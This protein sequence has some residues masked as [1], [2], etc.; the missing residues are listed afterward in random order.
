MS[1]ITVIGA[2]IT[3]PLFLCGVL[4]PVY[5]RYTVCRS[6]LSMAF[7]LISIGLIAATLVFNAFGVPETLEDMRYQFRLENWSLTALDRHEA[8]TYW[9]EILY[10]AVLLC[11][12]A[13][14]LL[15]V[16]IG[17]KWTKTLLGVCIGGICILSLVNI[18][19]YMAFRLT[20]G[21]GLLVV[22]WTALLAGLLLFELGGLGD[23]SHWK[24]PLLPCVIGC[25]NLVLL[26]LYIVLIF[27]QNLGYL[28][29]YL[30]MA[31][32]LVVPTLYIPVHLYYRQHKKEASE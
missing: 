7:Y 23:H 20:Y 13:C 3:V 21:I 31:V 18:G 1:T 12:V 28:Q 2:L 32:Q 19:I 22:D 10:H 29:A 14:L 27:I 9:F 4:Y 6:R 24:I 8:A 5:R 11:A 17:H 26:V 16:T 30:F 15:R 25:L